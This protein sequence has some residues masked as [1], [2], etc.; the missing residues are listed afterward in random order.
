MCHSRPC[1]LHDCVAMSQ[2][3]QVSMLLMRRSARLL[4]AVVAGILQ[5][6]QRDKPWQHNVVMADGGIFTGFT[7]YSGLVEEAITEMYGPELAANFNCQ[8][9]DSGSTMGAAAVAAA[10]T[11][12]MGSVGDTKTLPVRKASSAYGSSFPSRRTTQS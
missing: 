2:V 5:H 4:A 8:V 10:A 6:L 11:S 3:K 7:P 12:Y 1:W 9:T